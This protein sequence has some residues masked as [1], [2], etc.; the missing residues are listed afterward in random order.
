MPTFV[1]HVVFSGLEARFLVTH[2]LA[3]AP[4]NP[5]PVVGQRYF[6]T[7]L[8]REGVYNG[9]SWDYT[10]VAGVTSVSGIPP[11]VS[12]GGTSPAISITPASGGTAGSFSISDFLKLGASTAVNTAS[13]IVQR[14]SSGNFSA[15]M[16]TAMLTGTA[17]NAATLSGQSPASYLAR[18]NHTGTQTSAT[19]SDFDAQVRLNRLDQLAAPTVAVGFGG[20]RLTSLASPVSGSDAAT[21]EFVEAFVATGTNKGN[22]R[23]AST[24]N[25]NIAAPGAVIDGVTLSTTP[26]PDIVLVL[27]QTTGTQNGLYLFNGAASPMTRATNADIS[28][29]VTSGLFVFVVEGAVNALAGFTLV[30]PGPIV[31]GTTVLNFT[32]TSGAGQITAGLG[33]SKVGN[34]LNVGA[35]VGILVNPDDVAIDT[36][37]VARK[38][39]QLIGD[40][41]SSVITVTHTCNNFAPGFACVQVAAP[42]T[43]VIP[44][45][46][47]PTVS[48]A[49]FTF[50]FVP[51]PNQYRVTLIG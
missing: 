49:V 39:S 28:A 25:I 22:A 9:T 31:L 44:T 35:G 18:A 10:T 47:N 41:S 29:E 23:A 50:G 3:L 24:G 5:V 14:D 15:N 36:A 26:T 16:I 20:Q 8:L 48:T 46:T 45:M 34:V 13:A 6:D 40:G 43:S 17:S 37:I 2:K 30:T 11:M 4:T 1:D 32:Q 19:I 21:R 12:S 27:A 51:T 7:T 42:F 38:Y 33:Q